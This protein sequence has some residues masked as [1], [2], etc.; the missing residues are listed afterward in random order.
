MAAVRV[1]RVAVALSPLL[2][3]S[4]SATSLICCSNATAAD[5][6]INGTFCGEDACDG[7]CK[8]ADK[9]VEGARMRV[10]LPVVCRVTSATN[11]ATH[12]TATPFRSHTPPMTA[13]Y[14]AAGLDLRR[15]WVPAAV[16]G[17]RALC[18][19][20][21]RLLALRPVFLCVTPCDTDSRCRKLVRGFLGSGLNQSGSCGGCT[22][23]SVSGAYWNCSKEVK[24]P[25]GFVLT[26]DYKSCQEHTTGIVTPITYVWGRTTLALLLM[27]L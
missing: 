12:A 26:T 19:P 1:I 17:C 10:V 5:G 6:P 16:G 13:G 11:H 7:R 27:A 21:H 24:S 18:Q 15:R 22:C 2:A 4:A 9:L 8:G 3:S 25:N 23:W 14:R 20:L